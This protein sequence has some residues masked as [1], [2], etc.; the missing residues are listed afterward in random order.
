MSL[1]RIAQSSRALITSSTTLRTFATTSSLSR[2]PS[3]AD[4]TPDGVAAFNK[5]QKAFRAKL[6]EDA[7]PKPVAPSQSA[8]GPATVGISS[9]VQS[10]WPDASD[11]SSS[12]FTSE[13]PTAPIASDAGTLSNTLGLGSLSTA[14]NPVPDDGKPTGK[15]SSLI[16]GTKEGRQMD[17]EIEQ[18]FSQVLARGK[19]VHSIVFHHV[20]PDCVDEYVELV[21]GWYPKVAADPDNKVHLVGSW[22]TEV[23]DNET[24]SKSIPQVRTTSQ[25]LTFKSTS[26]ST[27][28]TMDTT[29]PLT[30][31]PTTQSSWISIR[32]SRS[33]LH[34][35]ES[36]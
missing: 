24:F 29:S 18:S 32:S 11:Y 1:L 8:T 9:T 15:L 31:F 25:K 3:L 10:S 5:K 35:R 27:G 19:Y 13:A 20:K 2:S 36:H 16:Y 7:K 30:P 26:G 33:S 6:A 21:G 28:S 23:G 12:H 17:Q 22:R 4:V 34:R 14:S